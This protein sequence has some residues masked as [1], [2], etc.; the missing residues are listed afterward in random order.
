MKVN[1]YIWNSEKRQFELHKLDAT[2]VRF[3]KTPDIVWYLAEMPRSLQNEDR[4]YLIAEGGTGYVLAFGADKTSCRRNA[5]KQF[6]KEGNA[7]SQADIKSLILGQQQVLSRFFSKKPGFEL[8][9]PM[10]KIQ[11]EKI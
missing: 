7:R 5:T 2:P 4:Q 11:L 8:P 1:W 9:K 6:S 10:K 3:S